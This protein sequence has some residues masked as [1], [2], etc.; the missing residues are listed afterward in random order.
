VFFGVFFL[1]AS[2]PLVQL[3]GPFVQL[4]LL[5]VALGGLFGRSVGRL[6]T[7]VLGALVSVLGSL[8]SVLGSLFPLPAYL[9]V[10]VAGSHHLSI[11]YPEEE[12]LSSLRE[13]VVK[14]GEA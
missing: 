11:P 8:V 4:G 3:L 12:I 1:Q 13:V 2:G 5:A 9:C 7:R 10:V 6:L 14:R